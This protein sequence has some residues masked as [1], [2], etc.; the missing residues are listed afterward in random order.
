[1]IFMTRE[2]MRRYDKVATER[3][4]VSG[5]VLMENAGRGAARVVLEAARERP[6]TITIVCGKGNNGGDGFVIARHVINSGRLAS[7][8]L[9]GRREDVGGDAKTN[10]DILAAM[11][12]S[13]T[14]IDVSKDMKS[15][16]GLLAGSAVVVDAIFGT[17]LEREVTGGHA[18]AIRAINDADAPVVAVDLP[19]GLDANTGRALGTA[20]RADATATFAC[21]KRGLVIHPG[22]ELAG[23]V[24]VVDIGAPG[25]IVQEVGYDGTMLDGADFRNDLGPRDPDVHKGTFGH[26][27]VVAGSPGKTGAAIM[28]GFAAMRTGAGLVTLAVPADLMQTVEAAKPPEVMLEPLLPTID[29]EVD[30]EAIERIDALLAGKS[31]VVIGPGCGLTD[32][33]E[34][35]LEVV[36]DR[37]NVPVVVD[38]DGLTLLS[39][40]PASTLDDRAHP[41]VLTPHPGEMSRLVW[42]SASEIQRERIPLAREYAKVKG[43]HLVLKG[44]RTVIASPDGNVWINPTG[45]AGMASGGT[46]DLLTGMIGSFIGQ[47][48]RIEDAVALGVYLHGL[49]GDRASEETGQRALVAGDVLSALPEVLLEFET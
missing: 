34:R 24:T 11:Q 32:S 13:I 31:A 38:A 27:L 37:A 42:K 30:G 21:L 35:V 28:A 26:L 41:T 19:S 6:G 23:E 12:G 43:V 9:L 33:M 3:Y 20:V 17:G 2:Q 25:C 16:P 14:E 18:E 10:A 8:V 49:A 4:G 15:L 36:L 5:T 47:G 44:A 22:V 45:N 29:A 40:L 1:M 39:R 46:G 7:I 48:H